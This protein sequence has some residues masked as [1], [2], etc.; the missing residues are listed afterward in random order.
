MSNTMSRVSYHFV[1][2]LFLYEFSVYISNDMIMPAMIYVIRD[3][4]VST[5]YIPSALSLYMLGGSSLQL[6]VGPFAEKYGK[7]KILLIGV[8]LFIFATAAN[9]YA[10]SIWQFLGSRIFQGMGIAFISTIGYATIQELYPEK[11]AVK[12]ISI[13]T[14]L[15]ILAPLFGPILGSIFLKYYNWRKI[16]LIIIGMSLLSFIGLFF[17]FPKSK[18]ENIDTNLLVYSSKC[19]INLLKNYKFIFGVLSFS[20]AQF[21]L[22]LWIAVSPILLIQNAKL[23]SIEYGYLQFPVFGGFIIGVL[24]LQYLLKKLELQI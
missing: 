19:Y 20:F 7:K 22:L 10:L 15:A 2:F 13:M 4:N 18:K 24:C 12:I 14:S 1:F 17:T 16:N 5:N 23:N 11:K 3:F 6:F 9:S 8:L 21:P